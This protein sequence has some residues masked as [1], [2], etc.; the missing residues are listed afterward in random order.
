MIVLVAVAVIIIVFARV[1]RGVE[2]RGRDKVIDLFFCI[3]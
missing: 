3:V 1:Y 2:G